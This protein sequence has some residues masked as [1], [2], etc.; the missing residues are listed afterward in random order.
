VTGA[1][2][3]G[4][5]I[6]TL[7][8]IGTAIFVI[9]AVAAT[10]FVDELGLVAA[11]VSLVLFA[12]GCVCFLWAYGV[13]IARSRT[14]AIGIG[15]LYFLQGTAPRDVQ[16]ALL[17]PLAVEVVVALAAAAIRPFTPLAFGVLVPMYGLGLA[18][19][20]GA[21]YGTFGPRDGN[22]GASDP[23]R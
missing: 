10:I 2:M 23:D 6:I 4:G 18:G 11:V 5:R 17:I 8:R 1:P 21:K 15:G 20:W 3:N 16:I 13:A 9:A 7:S 12:A 19:L 22:T 14:D